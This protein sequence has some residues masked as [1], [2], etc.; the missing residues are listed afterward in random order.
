MLKLAMLWF[1]IVLTVT[2]CFAVE[3]TQNISGS[4]ENYVLLRE[5]IDRLMTEKDK[6]YDLCFKNASRALD[7][8]KSELDRRLEELNE[9]RKSVE[10]DR[11]QF[12]KVESFNYKTEA[13]EHSISSLDKRITVIE[14]RIITWIGSIGAFFLIIQVVLWIWFKKRNSRK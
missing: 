1:F 13:I 4:R 12:V 11:I 14:T 7:L 5:Y 10:K 2:P 8:S 3:P 9:L 6:Y